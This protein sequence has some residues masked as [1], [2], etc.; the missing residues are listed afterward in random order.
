M[1]KIYMRLFEFSKF[2]LQKLYNYLHGTFLSCFLQLQWNNAHIYS[3]MQNFPDTVLKYIVF[4]Y[5]SN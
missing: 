4:D 2:K 5:L 1:Y 3:Y